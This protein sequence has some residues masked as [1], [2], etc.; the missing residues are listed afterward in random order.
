M[1]ST[2]H[3]QVVLRR[4]DENAC[5]GADVGIPILGRTS[6]STYILH[7]VKALLQQVMVHLY[8]VFMSQVTSIG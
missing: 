7:D 3:I 5:V 4:Y 8:M 1:R 2:A 6:V